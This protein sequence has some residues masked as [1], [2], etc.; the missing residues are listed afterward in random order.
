[1]A[2]LAFLKFSAISKM[3]GTSIANT[4]ANCR[5]GERRV[6]RNEMSRQMVRSLGRGPVV[7]LLRGAKMPQRQSKVMNRHF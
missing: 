1:V 5:D 4:I 6:P 7:E 3:C 2:K